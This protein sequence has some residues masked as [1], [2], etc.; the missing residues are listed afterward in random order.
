MICI[1]LFDFS[2]ILKQLNF[3]VPVKSF[4]CLPRSCKLD[5]WLRYYCLQKGFAR[6]V[7]AWYFALYEIRMD[8]VSEDILYI[9]K[10]IDSE[11]RLLSEGIFR[12][13]CDIVEN[14]F[15]GREARQKCP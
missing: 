14:L 11:T 10:V 8:F 1:W 5:W 15:S 6:A 13:C 4:R 12:G 3:E 2:E 7:L 9:R